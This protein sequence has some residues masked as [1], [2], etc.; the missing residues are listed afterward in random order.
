M[1]NKDNPGVVAPPPL[2]YLGAFLAGL[3]LDYFYRFPILLPRVVG[4][5][6]GVLL[7]AAAATVVSPAFRG[8]KRA[9]TN[10]EPWKPTTA[11]VTSGVYAFTR[12]PIYLALTLLYSGA[13]LLINSTWVLLLLAP[14]LTLIRFGVI[15]RE[16]RYLTAK[17]GVEYTN[18]KARVRR[19]I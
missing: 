19:W 9:R 18:Y 7:I 5:I 15:E 6:A 10:V 4:L 2:I 8:F 13:A 11:I 16:E 1:T 17:F 12:N 3:L 14:V